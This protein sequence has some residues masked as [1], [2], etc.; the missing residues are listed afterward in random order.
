MS[1]TMYQ[2]SVPVFTQLLTALSA[3]LDKA[4]AHATAKK[5]EPAALLNDRLYPDMFTFTRQV[6]VATDFARGCSA[7]LAGLEMPIYE[8]TEASFADLKARIKRTIDFMAGLKPAQIDG[9]EKRPIKVT[10]GGNPIAFEGEGY[11]TRFALPHFCFHCTTAY[12][13]LRHNGV[14]IGKRDYLGKHPGVAG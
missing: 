8:N 10:V 13:I 5:I 7:R 14:E 1:I 2:A 11:L 4:E 9:S 3:V 12:D 6:Q